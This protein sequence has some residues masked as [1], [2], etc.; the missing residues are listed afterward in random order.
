MKILSYSPMEFAFIVLV[1]VLPAVVAYFW[2]ESP[3]GFIGK[4]FICMM[5][6]FAIWLGLMFLVVGL[7]KLKERRTNKQP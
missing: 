7:Y 5:V 2:P 4:F 3:G 1:M 6:G